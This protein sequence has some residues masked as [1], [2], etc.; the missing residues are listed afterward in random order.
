MATNHYSL[1]TIVGTDTIDGV[2]AI[3]G[4]ANAVDTALY[5]VAGQSPQ[6]YVLPIATAG[7]LG[8]VRGGGDISVNNANGDMNIAAGVVDNSKLAANAVGSGNLQNNA[9]TASK[10]S[11]DVSSQLSAGYQASQ[12]LSAAPKQY[13]MSTT[14]GKAFGTYFVSEA[15]H[16]VTMK[17]SLQGTDVSV[18]GTNTSATSPS[19]TFNAIPAQFR[20]STTITSIV[21]AGTGVSGGAS[22]L[23][24]WFIYI[25]P[26]GVAGVY[27]QNWNAGTGAAQVWG[28]G[29]ITWVYGADSAA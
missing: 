20:P 27:Y 13:S 11:P 25:D 28:E 7:A 21:A 18:T 26:S 10:L 4:L 3:N 9:I 1:P 8:G 24:V 14:T 29:A 12:T 2:N 15:A 16:M 19:F 23:I 22:G 17:F 6:G 5:S